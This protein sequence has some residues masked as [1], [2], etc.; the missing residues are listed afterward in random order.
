MRK[1]VL[2]LVVVVLSLQSTAV[3]VAA[4]TPTPPG[5]IY[6]VQPNEYLSTIAAR[7]NVSINDLMA[8]NNLTDPNLIKVGQK[9]RIP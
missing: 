2:A 8:A 7:F 9:L 3:R 5:P 6:I 4:Q 1:S